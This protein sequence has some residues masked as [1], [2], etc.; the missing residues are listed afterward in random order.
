LLNISVLGYV[1]AVF[2]LGALSNNN[3]NTAYY[4]K[5]QG[6]SIVAMMCSLFITF[7][8]G[9]TQQIYA[10][11]THF[12]HP[13]KL[14]N[15]SIAYFLFYIP[16]ITLF[17]LFYFNFKLG[18]SYTFYFALAGFTYLTISCVIISIFIHAILN[19]TE[20]SKR[21]MFVNKKMS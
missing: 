20:K 14:I 18:Q 5:H 10:S 12:H 9:F 21:T 15:L 6:Y 17:T 3:H 19:L 7:I 16:F 2:L 4:A 13:L 1:L 11:F 8:H